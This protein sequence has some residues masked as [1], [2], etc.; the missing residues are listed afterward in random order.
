MGNFRHWAG[1]RILA[2]R[3]GHNDGLALTDV[4]DRDDAGSSVWDDFYAITT[5]GSISLTDRGPPTNGAALPLS[6]PKIP[7]NPP[8]GTIQQDVAE[9][10]GT[11]IDPIAPNTLA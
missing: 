11:S 4:T 6:T 8:T 2:D 10:G 1:S 3:N 5:I 7:A 9:L